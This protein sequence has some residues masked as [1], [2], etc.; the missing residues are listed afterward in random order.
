VKNNIK[1]L[2]VIFS[3]ILNIAFVAGYVARR[4]SERPTFA[5]EELDLSNDQRTRFE[6]ARNRFLSIL[7]ENTDKVISRHIELMDLIAAEPADRQ[8]ID[9]KFQEIRSIQRSMAHSVV[10]H[11]LEDKQILQPDQQEKFFAVLKSRIQKQGA[12]GPPWLPEG[13]RRR[14]Q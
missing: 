14:K 7:N 11:L 6:A 10:E 8:A 4:F 1:T 5:Y 12:P 13:A 2:A 9:L 3:V